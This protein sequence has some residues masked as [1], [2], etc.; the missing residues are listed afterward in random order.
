MNLNPIN[1]AKGRFTCAYLQIKYI[2]QNLGEKNLTYLPFNVS[3]P[4]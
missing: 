4:T 2:S 3:Q 1:A